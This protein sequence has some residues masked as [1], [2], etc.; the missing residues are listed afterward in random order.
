MPSNTIATLAA[1]ADAGLFERIATAVLRA[2]RPTV[3]GNVS[4]QGVNTDGKTVRASLDNVG[5]VRTPEGSMLVGAAHTTCARDDL[6][7]KW[8]HDPANVR[9]RKKGGTP[10]QP[11]GD[12]V[13]AIKEI[14]KL[15]EEHP[16][17]R[18]TLALT[19]NRE[20]PAEVRIKAEALAGQNNIVLDVWSV[21]R[22]ANFL[23]TNADGQAIRHEYLGSPVTRLSVPELMRIGR[24][25][26]DQLSEELEEP[27]VVERQ[28]RRS[29]GHL[30]LSGTSGMGK[31]TACLQVLRCAMSDGQPSLVLE[32]Q[33]VLQAGSIEE[34]IDIELRRYAPTLEA[35]AGTRALE[36][37]SEVRPLIVLV[38]D[39][40]RVPHTELVLNRLVL[41]ALKAKGPSKWRLLCPI[42]PRHLAALERAKEAQQASMVHVLGAYT[43]AEALEAVRRR[44]RGQGRPLDNL[45]AAAV[46]NALGCDPLLIGLHDFMSTQQPQDVIGSYISQELDRTAAACSM[47][48]TD[49]EAAMHALGQLMLK[50]RNL[51]P[52]WRDVAESLGEGTQLAALREI[53]KNGRVFRIATSASGELVQARHDRVLYYVLAQSIAP[54]LVAGENKAFHSDPYFAE[55]T[56]TAASMTCL[57]QPRLQELTTASPLVA[58]YAFKHAAACGSAYAKTAAGA[59]K[60]W[61]SAEEHRDAYHWSR[62][63]FGLVVL[64]EVEAP[65]VLEITG[66]FPK[67]NWRQPYFEARFRNGD[68][69]AAFDWLNEY[70][71][72][73]TVAGRQELVDHVRHKL[74]DRLLDQLSKVL[75]NAQTLTLN[76]RGALLLAGYVADPTLATAV[77]AAWDRTPAGERDLQ[78]FLWAAARVCGDRAYET[79]GPV[80][81]AWEALPDTKDQAGQTPRD[82]LAAHGVAWIFRDHVPRRALPYFVERAKQSEALQWPIVYMLKGVDD[83]VSLQYLVEYTAQKAKEHPD[84]PF[85]DHF[86]RDEWRRMTEDGK[87]YMSAPSKRRL[88]ALSEDKTNDDHLR[89]QAFSIWELSI[90]NEDVSIARGIRPDD[91]RYDK[92]VW[93]RARRQDLTVVQELLVK[94]SESPRYWWQA[95][96]Y[97]WSRELDDAL[98]VTLGEIAGCTEAEREKKG[99]W[100]V[101]ELLLGRE[102]QTGERLLLPVWPKLR[103]VREFFQT[104]VCLA[105]PQ[106]LQLAKEAIADAQEP[107]ALL[108][109][110]SFTARLRSAEGG[111]IDRLEQLDVLR[112]YF[113]LFEDLGLL[114]M[115]EVCGQRGWHEYGRQHLLPILRARKSELIQRVLGDGLTDLLDLDSE[116]KGRNWRAHFWM[117][118]RLR[119]GAKREELV[120]ALLEW[121]RSKMT[122]EALEIAGSV[123]SRDWGRGEFLRLQDVARRISGADLLLEQIKFNV[124]HRTLL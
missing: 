61:V 51:L 106:M 104:A 118:E 2:S 5:W 56:G 117:E 102:P 45:A 120:E 70:P 99:G 31:T 57:G 113:H 4:H 115:L 47:T 25:S 37:C 95:G 94:I 87:R 52:M 32:A 21:S 35:H 119:R 71:L 74:G 96:R 89:K 43:E 18:A 27:L 110:F 17:L 3:Y 44:S 62:R 67:D 12:L 111:K 69:T 34:A 15:R 30:L 90:D 114:D 82:S 50:C 14:S 16:G 58:F 73:V 76:L 24:Q 10:T 1:I 13:K 93:A 88:L 60:D 11:E 53:V 66:R 103:R 97:L 109:H 8:L 105:T 72:D 116:L 29:A 9:P 112:P 79:L 38:E 83:P 36:L 101:P 80:C 42:W 124:A 86:L 41:W 20:E 98:A 121:L 22:I 100:I 78:A 40:N 48:R 122:L 63:H 75:H 54:S 108:A 65:E 107:A 55:I 26:V 19:S 28:L 85:S 91:V 64:A 39:V 6:G 68:L 59:I 123:V 81:D 23:D 77:L 7:G 46:A 33:A 92:A 84:W 49:L